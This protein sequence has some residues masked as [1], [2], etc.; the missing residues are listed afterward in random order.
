MREG[1]VGEIWWQRMPNFI[2]FFK[3]LKN[4]FLITFRPYKTS[5]QEREMSG[6]ATVQTA[7]HFRDCLFWKFNMSLVP[8]EHKEVLQKYTVVLFRVD[9]WVP[10]NY[11][12]FENPL[13]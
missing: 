9:T 1:K 8:D 6:C 2:W 7:D 12:I 13:Q 3:I 5:D 11:F 4:H 10:N